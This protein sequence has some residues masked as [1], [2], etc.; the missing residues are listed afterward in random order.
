ML[1]ASAVSAIGALPLLTAAPA[2]AVT[3]IRPVGDD[4]GFLQFGAVAELLCMNL[5]RAAANRPGVSP[6]HRNW[7]LRARAADK[8]HY[9]L[10]LG[11]LGSDAPRFSDY[12]LA[13]LTRTRG[14]A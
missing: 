1:V 14:S 5:Y 4:L 11:P 10:L 8:R 2:G 12:K 13:I 7:L 6:R 3:P 9:D